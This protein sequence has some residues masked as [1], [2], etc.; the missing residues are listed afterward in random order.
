M[1][2]TDE[3]KTREDELVTGR[4]RSVGI[5]V[6]SVWDLVNSRGPYPNAIPVLVE[7][8]PQVRH[9]RVKEGIVRALMDPTAGRD[10]VN[11]LL[12][13]FHASQEHSVKWAIGNALSELARR[14]DLD[15]L[16]EI[17]AARKHGT[18]RQMVISG[19]G[20]RMFDDP[21]TVDVLIDALDDEGVAGHA[22]GALGKLR[23][24]KA[25]A[26][27]RGFL[28]HSNDWFRKTAATALRRIEED[29]SKRSARPVKRG[30]TGGKR[31]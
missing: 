30:K 9:P 12:E 4:L 10:A 25:A 28:D 6:D 31:R 8:L 29:G 23:A 14:E 26:R 1:G 2:T 20:K 17:A 13:E 11:A 7:M 15:T 21:R 22:L 19:L 24:K 3:H 18:T 5:E 27:V 16:L